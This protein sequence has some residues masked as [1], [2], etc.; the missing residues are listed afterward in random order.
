[1][2]FFKLIY[3]NVTIPIY[4]WKNS[5]SFYPIVLWKTNFPTVPTP[6]R[7]Y[8]CGA[9]NSIILVSDFFVL[10]II[11][12]KYLA[13]YWIKKRNTT[14]EWIEYVWSV[15]HPCTLQ[16]I[17]LLGHQ[18]SPS[19][20]SNSINLMYNNLFCLKTI[21]SWNSPLLLFFLSYFN[22]LIFFKIVFVL[23][24]IAENN[25]IFREGSFICLY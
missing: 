6:S 7:K 4:K 1:M 24:F 8:E 3:K 9:T 18:N 21:L 17:G 22:G 5:I 12:A 19:P 20:L 10:A 25:I 15:I 2:Q 11:W 14:S 16:T 13:I 23:F